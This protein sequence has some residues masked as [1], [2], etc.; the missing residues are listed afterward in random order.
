MQPVTPACVAVFAGGCE[1]PDIVLTLS[2]SA[3]DS[4]YAPYNPRPHAIALPTLPAL[5]L[6]QNSSLA[7]R[8]CADPS[9]E[10]YSRIVHSRID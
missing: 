1:A 9:F 8:A 4:D 5:V 10:L 2:L 3:A 6:A 7:P